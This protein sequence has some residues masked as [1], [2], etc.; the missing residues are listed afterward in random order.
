MVELIRS[1]ATFK[2]DQKIRIGESRGFA[3]CL[4]QT[5]RAGLVGAGNSVLKGYLN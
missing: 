4:I 1:R 2:L 3:I 5:S